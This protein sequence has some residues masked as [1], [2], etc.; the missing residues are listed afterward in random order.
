MRLSA[1]FRT[2]ACDLVILNS[3]VCRVPCWVLTDRVGKCEMNIEVPSTNF[4]SSKGDYLLNKT[5]GNNA[6]HRP[7][8]WPVEAQVERFILERTPGKV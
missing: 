2:L 5:T 1:S 7:K 4:H 3:N 6:G 8:P